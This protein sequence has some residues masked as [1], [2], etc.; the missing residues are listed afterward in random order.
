MGRAV[1]P[2]YSLGFGWNISRNEVVAQ[3]AFHL[4]PGM[5]PVVKTLFTV[6]AELLRF[7][8]TWLTKD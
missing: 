8:L 3:R 1:L 7:E 6:A 5:W 2:K 4:H